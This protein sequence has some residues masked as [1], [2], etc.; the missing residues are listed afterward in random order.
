[1]WFQVVEQYSRCGLTIDLYR[2]VSTAGFLYFIVMLSKPNILLALEYTSL[3]SADDFKLEVKVRGWKLKQSVTSCQS[4]STSS[5]LSELAD[6]HSRFMPSEFWEAAAWNTTFYNSLRLSSAGWRML[7]LQ[8]LV[9]I[10]HCSWQTASSWGIFRR[11]VRAGLHPAAGPNLHQLVFDGD[12]ALCLH[13]YWRI[14]IMYCDNVT[15][16]YHSQ[17]K[18]GLLLLSTIV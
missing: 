18:H 12:E 14:N 5:M 2:V 4:V 10:R 9:G 7:S 11:A 17:Q 13:E 6:A 8:C 15:K 3:R 1:M 16:Y